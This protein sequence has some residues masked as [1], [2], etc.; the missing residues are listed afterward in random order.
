[1]LRLGADILELIAKTI[2]ILQYR[3]VFSIVCKVLLKLPNVSFPKYRDWAMSH[4]RCT[5]FLHDEEWELTKWFPSYMIYC[6]RCEVYKKG[7]HRR[8]IGWESKKECDECH[9]EA[10]EHMK[11]A[12]D[13]IRCK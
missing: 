10:L 5:E 12:C 8:R 1:M 6:N 9:E 13:L 4:A 7:G 3:I 11:E 2:G